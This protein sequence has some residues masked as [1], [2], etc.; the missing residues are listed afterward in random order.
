[1]CPGIY[2]GLRPNFQ[3][4]TYCKNELLIDS[5]YLVPI[6]IGATKFYLLEHI[7]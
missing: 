7:E 3:M 1:M 5:V 4:L 2:T 6:T